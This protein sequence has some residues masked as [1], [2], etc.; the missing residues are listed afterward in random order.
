MSGFWSNTVP[1][2]QARW[3]LI[4]SA[5]NVLSEAERVEK[6]IKNAPTSV[7]DLVRAYAE[8]DEAW[9][10]LDTHHRHMESRKY[11]F[12]FAVGDEHR[13]LEKLIAKA[14]QR[15]TEVGSQ[16]AKHFVTYFA[17]TKHPI[18]GLLR[19]RDFF[20]KRVKPNLAKA[21]SRTYGSTRF[22]LKWREN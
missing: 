15:Y 3:A 16:L 1:A 22:V 2:I 20:E 18:V 11:N 5:A 9:C 17:K 8:G 21:R 12:E 13:N 4:L 14:E 10:L 19:Q 6:E 7:Q